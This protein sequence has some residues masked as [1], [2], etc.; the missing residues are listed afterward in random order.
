MREKKNSQWRRGVT[1][2][3]GKVVGVDDDPDK[4]VGVDDDPGS[5]W[6]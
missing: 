5:C 3:A 4:V 6:S 2:I 1:E